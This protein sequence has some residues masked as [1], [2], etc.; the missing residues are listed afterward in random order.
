MTTDPTP[1]TRRGLHG[2]DVPTYA[3]G[4]AVAAFSLVPL[5][6]VVDAVRAMGTDELR[7]LL[8]RPRVGELL[9]NTLTLLGGTVALTLVIGVGAALLVVRTD[10]PWKPLWHAAFAAPLAVPAFVN[11]YAWV[12]MTHAV[13]SY[14]GAVLVVSLSYFPLVYLPVAATLAGLDAAPEEVAR[15]LGRG[16]VSVLAGVVLPRVAPAI[17]GG[18]LLVGLHV[19]AEFGALQ[20]LAYQTFTTAV[21]GQYSSAFAG[22]GGTVLAGV[23]L[24]LCLALL[25]VEVVLRGRRRIARSGRGGGQ[26]AEPLA[27]G[28]LRWPAVLGLAAFTA[29]SLG[30][31]LTALVRWMLVGSS[32]RFPV[33]TLTTALGN[34][35]VLGLLGGAVA[36]VVALVPAWLVVRRPGVASVLVE[37]STYLS[38]AV[39]G[40]VV[41]LSLVYFSIKLVPELYLTTPVLVAAYVL[42]FLPRAVVGL[43]ATWEQVPVVLDEV[44]ASLGQSPLATFRRVAL[45]LIAPGVGAAFALC[46]L[47]VATELTAT[48]VLAPTGTRTLATQ[49]WSHSSAVEYGAA[50]PYAVLLVLISAPA[51][52]LLAW[53]VRPRRRAGQTVTAS[54]P[55]V[56]VDA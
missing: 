37:R 6:Y 14:G 46:F 16:R 7:T 34:T 52:A 4:A 29:V 56:G 42:L 33:D 24:V 48:L 1:G 30:V 10:V 39:P 53:Q 43:R 38:S 47:A 55:L 21:Y 41:A 32:T 45:P 44:S 12:S 26:A 31:P 27:L 18:A 36:T 25:A 15:S 13:Q 50:A 22:N 8:I 20:M 11:S 51:T 49:F 17:T 2:N 28:A 5:V 40:I 19:L 54:A 35:L 3:V 9:L 23:L